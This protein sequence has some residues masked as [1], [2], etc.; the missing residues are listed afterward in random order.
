MVLDCICSRSRPVL[1]SPTSRARPLDATPSSVICTCQHFEVDGPLCCEGR[2]RHD[3]RD[4]P[5]LQVKT[6]TQVRS[7]CPGTAMCCWSP[8]GE[9]LCRVL[10]TPAVDGNASQGDGT[11]RPPNRASGMCSGLPWRGRWQAWPWP[12]DEVV[13]TPQVGK[14]GVF[15]QWHCR[16][17]LDQTLGFPVDRGQC[18]A[19]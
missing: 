17:T 3:S 7:A 6:A 13:E 2:R 12:V 11:T 10:P 8:P 1:L 19:T 14:V 9:S 4:E 18:P 15:A 5:A 16:L